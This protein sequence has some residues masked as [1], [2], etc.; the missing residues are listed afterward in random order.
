MNVGIEY[1]RNVLEVKIPDEKVVALH[2]QAVVAGATDPAEAV[3]IALEAPE[4]YPPLRSALTPDDHVA[5]VVDERLP[6]VAKLVTAVLDHVT[7]AGVDDS[8]VT[9]V[10]P[11][12]TGQ[13]NWIDELPDAY[14][15]VRVEVHNPSDRKRLAY[16]ATTQAGRRIYL[17][18]TSVESDQLVVLAQLHYDPLHG[19]LGA[20]G[21]VHPALSD[22]D[23]RR[24]WEK[25]L[26]NEP[27]A[28]EP[29]PVRRE[30][31]EVLWLL[32]APFLIQVIPGHADEVGQVV[33]GA[34][35]SAVMA[36][37]GLDQRWRATA[38]SPAN[39][40][41]ASISGDPHAQSIGVLARS[42]ASAARV[43]EPGGTVVVMS[44]A[45]PEIGDG[46]RR[47]SE[48]AGPAAALAELHQHPTADYP[49]AYQWLRA[50]GQCRIVLW[51]GL[52]DDESE[53]LFVSRLE[54]PR[55]LQ[56]LIDAASSCLFL[57]DAHHLLAVAATKE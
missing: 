28:D 2:R 16:L 49:A 35:E 3:R 29:W 50:A 6:H 36:R 13:Q 47:A 26:T 27:P 32:G 45:H 55:Q 21:L 48:F 10:F 11:P 8:A 17:N 14:G 24:A 40:V 23:V 19:Y 22:D 9:L 34:A 51:S 39:L 46:L 12:G 56:R 57:P 42:M 41:V 38:S 43:V 4:K 37:A 1:G 53:S 18:R 7:T 54:A 52:T 20:A 33:A 44:D 15:S 25:A 5:I 31:E 30:A